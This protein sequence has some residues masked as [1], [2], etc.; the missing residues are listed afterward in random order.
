LGLRGGFQGELLNI[1][2]AS[3]MTSVENMPAIINTPF[4]IIKSI[5]NTALKPVHYFP[6]EEIGN[7]FNGIHQ[8]EKKNSMIKP[9]IVIIMLESLSKKYVGL[10]NK[11]MK[12]PFMDSIFS[13][14]LLCTN[15]FANAKIS[16]QGVPAVL[17]SIP[18]WQDDYFVLSSYGTNKISSFANLLKPKGYTTLFYHGGRNGSMAL[19]TYSSLAG[20]DTYKGM[21]QYNNRNDYDGNWGI[22]DEPYLQYMAKDLSSLKQPFISAVLTVSSHPPFS[23]PEKYKPV[24]KEDHDPMVRCV[25]Y[26]DHALAEFFKTAKQQPWFSN[27]LFVFTAD[28]TAHNLAESTTTPLDTYSIPIVFYK[29]DGSMK[30]IHSPIVSQADI[31]PTVFHLIN[32]PDPYFSIGRNIFNSGCDAYTINYKAGIYQYFDSAY[33]YQFNGSRAVGLYNTQSDKTLLNNVLN[34]TIL[35]VVK[36]IDSNLKK[37]IQTF[38]NSM[39]QNKMYLR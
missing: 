5:N 27:T 21:N 7:C 26:L 37:M 23:I 16:I 2:H 1:S 15:A 33:C 29:P 36:T 20:F 32:Y 38:N 19:D 34:D 35:P 17:S 3:Q 22:W 6:D 9:N 13:E 39:L 8:P 24:F 12:T 4:S 18:S 28:H 11:E 31:L 25:Q 14:G 30:G 10:F